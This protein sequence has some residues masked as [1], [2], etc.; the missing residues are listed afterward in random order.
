M[1]TGGQGGKWDVLS[2]HFGLKKGHLQ[3]TKINIIFDIIYQ[4]LG[5]VFHPISKNREEG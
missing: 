4:A 5:R 1:S 3:C 2:P